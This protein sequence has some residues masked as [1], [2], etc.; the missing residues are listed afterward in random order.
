MGIRHHRKHF[1]NK[2]EM[3]ILGLHRK[4]S[5]CSYLVCQLLG[6]GGGGGDGL[7]GWGRGGG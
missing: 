1:G 4:F 5:L 2:F 3:K 6:G 7:G